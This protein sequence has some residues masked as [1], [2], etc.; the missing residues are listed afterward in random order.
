MQLSVPDRLAMIAEGLELISEHVGTLR[1]DLLYL[2]RDRR[3]RAM[4]VVAS[5]SEEESAKALILLDIV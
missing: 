2:D 1:E 3:R 4:S 5:Q